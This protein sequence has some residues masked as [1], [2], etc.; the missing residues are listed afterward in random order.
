MDGY[1]LLL[2]LVCNSAS[3]AINCSSCYVRQTRVA[4]LNHIRLQLFYALF[5]GFSY[6]EED[7]CGLYKDEGS[8]ELNMLPINLSGK[9]ASYKVPNACRSLIELLQGRSLLLR[10]NSQ[11]TTKR[12]EKET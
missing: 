12:P 9:P 5:Q 7:E 1:W 6:A 3:S 11:D 8:A 2:W 4:T 10:E